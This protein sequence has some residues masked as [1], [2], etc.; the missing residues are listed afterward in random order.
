M[1]QRIRAV[2]RDGHLVPDQALELPDE[3]IVEVT[4]D[5][6]ILIPPQITDPVEREKRMRALLERM[7]GNPLPTDAPRFTREELHERR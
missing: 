6:P 4:I 3:S 2:Y 7:K 1:I 5:G